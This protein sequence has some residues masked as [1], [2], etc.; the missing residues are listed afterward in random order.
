MKGAALYPLATNPDVLLYYLPCLS[1]SV[2]RAI[3]APLEHHESKDLPACLARGSEAKK[4]RTCSRRCFPKSWPRCES[5]GGKLSAEPLPSLLPRRCQS[6]NQSVCQ[7]ERSRGAPSACVPRKAYPRLVSSR[8]SAPRNRLDELSGRLT[9][10]A[11]F[12]WLLSTFSSSFSDLCSDH[13]THVAG[14]M[15]DRNQ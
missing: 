14:I 1:T 3:R 10:S 5:G 9:C 13:G 6:V 12:C 15:L 11:L 4:S 7:S 2:S 8:F